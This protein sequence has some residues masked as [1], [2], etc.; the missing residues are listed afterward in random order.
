MWLIYVL[1]YSFL[2]ALVN[3]I[4]EY[5]T[6]NNK[7]PQKTN[8]HTRIGGLLLVST[9]L[10]FV[11][12][13]VVRVIYGDVGVSEQ[14]LFLAM[15]SAIPMVLMWG[16]YFYLLTLYPVYQ[17]LPLF[18]ISSLWMLGIE[19]LLGGSITFIGLLGVAAL[20]IGAYLLD[21]G[22]FRLK[23]PTKLLLIAIP[24]TS[25]WAIVL[26]M[27][28]IASEEASTIAISFWQM[29]ATGII[30]VLLMVFVQKYREGFL[31]RIRRQGKNF[32]GFSLLNESFSQGGYVFSNLAVAAAPVAT[33]VTAMS[34]VQSVFVLLLF[35][36]F[37]QKERTRITFLQI[38]AICL[39]VLGVFLIEGM[40]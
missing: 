37:P 22:T 5:L 13:G 24:V 15:L 1:I 25:L 20:M 4:D 18:Q 35:L 36:F 38:T 30:G 7:V 29:I 26:I 6:S 23:V 16:S 12:A 28:R 17:V 10:T 14:A 33:Y 32:L 11:G 39:I 3:Y 19:L 31:Y 21:A 40:S 2:L 9:L 34:G 27:V 8:I